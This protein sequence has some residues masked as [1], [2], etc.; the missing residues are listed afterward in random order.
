MELVY[1][2]V[3]DYKN[4]QKQGFNFSPRFRCE[5]DDEK[6]ELTIE[7]NDDYIENFFGD[8]INVTAIVGKNGSGKSSVL[9]YLA[10]NPKFIV[11]F[12]NNQFFINQNIKLI[13][14]TKYSFTYKIIE[15][16]FQHIVS[17]DYIVNNASKLDELERKT[18]YP[19]DFIERGDRCIKMQIERIERSWVALR[20]VPY[21][22]D[23]TQT[24]FTRK[25]L[26]NFFVFL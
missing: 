7:E 26:K 21:K 19:K 9:E 16:E 5:Y 2:W 14:K 25:R 22:I 4:I 10:E 24:P 18:E 1:L 8:N 12:E 17:S 20:F 6:N 13:N 23:P 11:T 15:L 3:E